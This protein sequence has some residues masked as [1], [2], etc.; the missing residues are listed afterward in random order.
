M[1][2]LPIVFVLSFLCLSNT[3]VSDIEKTKPSKKPR[4]FLIDEN[5]ILYEELTTEYNTFL[6]TACDNDMNKAINVW[7][8][9]L[10]QMQNYAIRWNYNE[11]IVGVKIWI[12]L[13]CNKKG[14]IQ[15]IAYA[16]KPGSRNVDTEIFSKFLERF[17][18]V[19]RLNVRTNKKFS[20]YHSISFPIKP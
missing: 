20:H 10:E 1:K 5:E 8:K 11:K 13:F 4:V 3:Y 9:T 15:H 6:L 19:Y 16:V 7:N 17:L 18:R 14:R 12:R 2:L